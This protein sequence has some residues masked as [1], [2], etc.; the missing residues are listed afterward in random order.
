[1]TLTHWRWQGCVDLKKQAQAVHPHFE[2][3]TVVRQEWTAMTTRGFPGADKS[4]SGRATALGTVR[5]GLRFVGIELFLC[6]INFTNI[7]DRSAT[8]FF[9]LIQS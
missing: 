6:V 8:L 5:A 1:M 9:A 7:N 3:S 2:P 4:G